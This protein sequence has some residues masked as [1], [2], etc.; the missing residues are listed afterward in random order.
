MIERLEVR[1]V[2]NGYIVM[3]ETD[4]GDQMEY[5]FD[6]IRKA[7]RFIKEQVEGKQSN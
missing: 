1:K 4:A 6:T 2:S 5:V 3:V 7:M